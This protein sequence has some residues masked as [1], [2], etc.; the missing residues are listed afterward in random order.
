MFDANVHRES[1][2]AA[3]IA[4]LISTSSIPELK[5]NMQ[6]VLNFSMLHEK[7]ACSIFQLLDRGVSVNEPFGYNYTLIG[8]VTASDSG[9]LFIMSKLLER[10]ADPTI[11]CN[12]KGQTALHCCVRLNSATKMELL[13]RAS[14]V[15]RLNYRDDNDYTALDMAC[16]LDNFDIVK[17]LAEAGARLPLFIPGGIWIDTPSTRYITS[18]LPARRLACRAAINMFVACSWRCLRGLDKNIIRAIVG[19]VWAS[20]RFQIWD[21]E[22][23]KKLQL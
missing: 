1:A 21:R 18:I 4:H 13:L 3:S 20:R 7:T 17:L 19:Q 16:A 14:P 8:A 12:Q 6:R 5:K 2:N 23:T 10:G 22:N 15:G 9:N 11:V